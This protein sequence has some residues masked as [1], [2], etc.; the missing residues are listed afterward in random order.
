MFVLHMANAEKDAKPSKASK[1]LRNV[2]PHATPPPGQRL[3]APHDLRL[4]AEAPPLL[5]FDLRE[6]GLYLVGLGRFH[7]VLRET[8]RDGP[9]VLQRASSGGLVCWQCQKDADVRRGVCLPFCQSHLE[10][11]PVK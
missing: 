11:V 5:L 8:S 6:P 7:V 1:L 9:L 2:V 3:H 10:L 4:L